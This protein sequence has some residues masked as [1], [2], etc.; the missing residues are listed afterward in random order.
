MRGTSNKLKKPD[1]S[2]PRIYVPLPTR[3]IPTNWKNIQRGRKMARN[4]LFR[5]NNNDDYS[6]N[7]F[8]LIPIL[9]GL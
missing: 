6:I 3:K 2:I 1:Q 9:Y 7:K 8:P 4:V 5:C